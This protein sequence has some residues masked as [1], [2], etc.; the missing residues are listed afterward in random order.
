MGLKD[1][2]E[3]E[4]IVDTESI[5][6]DNFEEANQL[7]RIFQDGTIDIDDEYGDRPWKEK[8]LIHLIG[9]QYA[10]EADKVETPS[11]PYEF[12]YARVDVDKSTVR[13]YMNKLADELIVTKTEEDDEW[14]LVADNLP[15]ALNRIGDTDS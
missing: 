13:K 9:R 4:M 15:E 12:F 10:F 14:K 7:F 2:I 6:E 5:L 1:R 11:L 3:D 8:I